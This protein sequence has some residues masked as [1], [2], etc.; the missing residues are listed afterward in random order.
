MLHPVDDQRHDFWCLAHRDMPGG[1]HMQ[2]PM[3]ISM[4]DDE[5]VAAVAPNLQHYIEGEIR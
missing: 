5:L 1:V 2:P 4:S 3:S